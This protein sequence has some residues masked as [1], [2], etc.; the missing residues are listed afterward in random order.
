MNLNT[1]PVGDRV[2]I[3][4]FG[5]VNTGKSSLL[6]ALVGQPAAIVSD[7]EGTTTDPVSKT[8]EIKDIGP[9]VIFDT[10]GINDLTGLGQQRFEKT[11]QV[12]GKTDIAIINADAVTGIGEPEN[13]LAALLSEK[14]I[15][16]ITVI[17]KADLLTSAL[18]GEYLTVSAK[19]G[20]GI[21]RIYTKL[22]ELVKKHSQTPKF[23][24]ISDLIAPGDVIVL[25][26]PIDELA[27]KGRL[28]LPQQQTVR[29]I[30]DRN[31]IAVLTSEKTLEDTLS[32]L[33]KKPR[34]VV[35]DS[36]VF[37]A[38]SETVPKDV[39][40]T[41]FSVLFA[42][43][44]GELQIFTD[45]LNALGRLQDGD[46][47]LIAEG[48]THRMN[49]NDGH[50]ADGTRKCEEIGTVKIPRILRELTGRD[51]IFETVN[52][53]YFPE[54]IS[55]FSLVI[56]CGG[57]MLG[58]AEMRRRIEICKQNNV[59]VTN[60]GIFLAKAAGVDFRRAFRCIGIN[61][62]YGV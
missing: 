55:Q 49:T 10:A 53:N 19:T 36:G 39:P 61:T 25:V 26:I 35:T 40:L 45:G 38:V 13:K 47:I 46:K 59:P 9:A 52:G 43:H 60:F 34:M 22:A 62:D 11:A 48:C 58:S 8:L 3:G 42:R 16:Y 41:S 32:A 2:H 5:R 24:V 28:I 12:L 4:I 18:T 51:L 57:C 21:D 23:P 30:V 54:N 14:K 15:P 50:P 1:T 20:E 7:S 44:K 27:P 56:H 31:A 6:N 17:N 29:E 37:P 33:G